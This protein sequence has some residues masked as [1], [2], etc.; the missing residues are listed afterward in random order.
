MSK[1]RITGGNR[2]MEA[3]PNVRDNRGGARHLRRRAAVLQRHLVDDLVDAA[4]EIAQDDPELLRG[5][6]AGFSRTMWPDDDDMKRRGLDRD[7]YEGALHEA[8]VR[9]RR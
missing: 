1:F 2:F 5:D 7:R 6:Y 9:V 4:R 3:S 8:W